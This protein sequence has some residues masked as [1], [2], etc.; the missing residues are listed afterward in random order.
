MLLPYALKLHKYSNKGADHLYSHS[1]SAAVMSS[2][3][4]P[5]SIRPILN[6]IAQLLSS[7]EETISVAETVSRF[8]WYN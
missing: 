1:W 3:F 6:E 4:P 7:R 8:Q 5:A 2:E